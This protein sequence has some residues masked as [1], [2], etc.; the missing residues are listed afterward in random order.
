MKANP[1]R[2]P[3]LHELAESYPT[4]DESIGMVVMAMASSMDGI[5]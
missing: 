2:D 4:M 5:T 3:E 1:S